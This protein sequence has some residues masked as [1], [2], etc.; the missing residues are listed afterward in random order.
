MRF[1]MEGAC[2][3]RMWNIAEDVDLVVRCE[4]NGVMSY[5]G[6]EQFLLIKALNDYDSKVSG[7]HHSPKM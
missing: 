2:R 5:K 3:Y 6:E 1:V 7:M 4:L